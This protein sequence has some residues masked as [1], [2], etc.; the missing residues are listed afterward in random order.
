MFVVVR[1]LLAAFEVNFVRLEQHPLS[2]DN[3]ELKK[4]R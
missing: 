4:K 2:L 1:A 3:R